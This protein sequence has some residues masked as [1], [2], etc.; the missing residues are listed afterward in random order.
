M[1]K[2]RTRSHIIADLSV[3]HVERQ[4]L[5]CGYTMERPVYDY[6]IDLTLTTYAANGEV[7]EG[8]VLFQ[9]KA[10]DSLPLSADGSAIL[11]QL[12]RSDLEL[13]LRQYSPVIFVVY[14]AQADAAYWLYIQA[15]FARLSNFDLA[16][17]NQTTM[18]RVPISNVLN[19][20]AVRSFARFRDNI[21]RQTQ[22][23]VHD[24][25]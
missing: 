22:Q 18:V 5:L 25:N 21:L 11:F 17:S 8:T 9:L 15:Y 24:D 7:E 1:R 16:T 12:E 6:G 3:N 23:V 2:R 4:A 19:Q 10:T 20:E 13:W 14:D